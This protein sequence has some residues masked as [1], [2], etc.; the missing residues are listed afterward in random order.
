[1][2]NDKNGDVVCISEVSDD[3]WYGELHGGVE[4]DDVID[5][6]DPMKSRISYDHERKSWVKRETVEWLRENPESK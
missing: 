6:L 1:M 4:R 3:G 5:K 2:G